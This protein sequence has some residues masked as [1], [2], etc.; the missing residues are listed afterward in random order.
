MFLDVMPTIERI[1]RLKGPLTISCGSCGHRVTWT[2][3]EA[4]CRLGGECMTTDA[5]KRLWCSA[6]GERRT[7]LIAFSS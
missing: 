3:R 4:A 1:G 2:A 5:R 6:C 7:Y